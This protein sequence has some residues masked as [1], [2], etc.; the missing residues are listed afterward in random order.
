M[1]PLL[2]VGLACATLTLP[3]QAI[4]GF[5]YD[6]KLLTLDP[7]TGGVS[8]LGAFA[9]PPTFNSMAS[10][11]QGAV[12]VASAGE[13]PGITT[14]F[15]VD[16]FAITLIPVTTVPFAGVRALAFDAADQLYAIRN[17]GLFAPNVL[18]QINL[19]TGGVSLVGATVDPNSAATFSVLQG[20]ATAPGGNVFYAWDVTGAGGAGLVTVDPATGATVDVNPAFLPGVGGGTQ[21]LTFSPSG[22]LFGVAGSQLLSFDL[23]TGVATPVSTPPALP[24]LDVRGIEYLTTSPSPTW[25]HGILCSPNLIQWHLVGGTPLNPYY[26]AVA[27]SYSGVQPSGW[28]FGIN[29]TINEL[30]SQLTY[31]GPPFLGTLDSGG[32][33]FG[34]VYSAGACNGTVV[35]DSVALEISLTTGLVT[36]ATAP[37]T[38]SL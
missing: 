21:S 1:K 20:M 25:S 30:I 12:Y 13:A 27:A 34:L 26:L 6:G 16:P 3:G 5:T 24:L 33:A 28:F 32:N 38:S 22:Q 14:I 29:I 2:L 37:I 4:L 35:L 7:S 8:I 11:S 23:T 9:S 31:G 17:V 15:L 36:Q 18:Y 19:A 10:D